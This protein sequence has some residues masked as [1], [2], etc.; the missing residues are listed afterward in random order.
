MTQLRYSA[1]LSHWLVLG[2]LGNKVEGDAVGA[3]VQHLAH[4]AFCQS[5]TC[6]GILYQRLA[7]KAAQL[8]V[9]TALG[10]TRGDAAYTLD[11]SA[12]DSNDIL[13]LA[14]LDGG[15]PESGEQ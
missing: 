10:H 5:L 7:P 13:L 3:T 14:A 8:R 4:A 12:P 1:R 9:Y 11:M 2:H 15:P 6:V